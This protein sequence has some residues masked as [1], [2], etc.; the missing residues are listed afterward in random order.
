MKKNKTVQYTKKKKR[1]GGKKFVGILQ[2]SYP[3]FSTFWAKIWQGHL[4]W[5]SEEGKV[6]KMHLWLFWKA[7]VKAKV[8]LNF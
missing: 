1:Q 5:T 8:G 4:E 6:K 3:Q 2:L 7:P